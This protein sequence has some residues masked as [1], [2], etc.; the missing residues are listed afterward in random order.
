VLALMKDAWALVFPSLYYE[1]FPV[2]IAEAY[3][4]GLPII[5][6]DVGSMSLLIDHGRTGLHVRSADAA[7]LA[8]KLLWLW[9]HPQDRARMSVNARVEFERKYTAERNYEALMAIYT[10]A[11]KQSPPVYD[12]RDAIIARRIA[13]RD[14]RVNPG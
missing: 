2:V 12:L 4:A 9:A 3:A 10:R 14:A 5:A 1:N 7:D 11:T 6:S 13:G 8:A